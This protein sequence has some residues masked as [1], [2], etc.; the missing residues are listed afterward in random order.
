VALG[1]ADGD[2]LAV[3]VAR[4]GATVPPEPEHPAR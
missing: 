3:G 1:L 2:G 4:M